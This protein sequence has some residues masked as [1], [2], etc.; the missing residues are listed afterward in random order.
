[1]FPATE[2]G[3]S[4]PWFYGHAA[5]WQNLPTTAIH[6]AQGRNACR[7]L[8]DGPQWMSGS[9]LFNSMPSGPRVH[10]R[11]TA[12][13][14]GQAVKRFLSRRGSKKIAAPS[15]TP[16]LPLEVQ[17]VTLLRRFGWLR[18]IPACQLPAPD[19]SGAG[20]LCHVAAHPPHRCESHR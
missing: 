4:E 5:V 9:T 16:T 1:M 6:S 7:N 10:A 20:V 19:R 12:R 15:A 2:Q 13:P 8:V 18:L 3:E 11:K 14:A 17:P